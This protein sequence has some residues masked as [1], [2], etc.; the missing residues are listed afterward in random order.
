MHSACARILSACARILSACARMHSAC[1]RIRGTCAPIHSL[2]A[3]IHSACA[4]STAA[5]Q[6]DSPDFVEKTPLLGEKRAWKRKNRPRSLKNLSPAP[7]TGWKL[8]KSLR[9]PPVAAYRRISRDPPPFRQIRDTR[10]PAHRV[11][12][13]SPGV[14]AREEAG[15]SFGHF[16]PGVLKRLARGRLPS[17]LPG[18]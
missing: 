1:A 17:R 7:K 13:P 18:N 14:Q 11:P 5:V 15:P 8:S 4:V 9:K 10:Q 3:R 2:C 6:A 12:N 16:V